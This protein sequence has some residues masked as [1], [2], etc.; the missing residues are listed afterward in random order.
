MR[1]KKDECKSFPAWLTSFSDLMSLLLTF[2]IL[3]YSMS[4]LDVS[5]AAKF[6]SYFQGE[7]AKYF[8][9]FSIVKPIK[10]YTKDLAKKLGKILARTLPISGY[11]IVV[12]KQYVLLRIFNRVLF[13]KNSFNLTPEAKKALDEVVKTIKMIDGNYTIRVE[14]HTDIGEPK[15]PID[16]IKDS[17]DLSLRRATAVIRYFISKGIPQDR[18]MA[19][20][21]GDTRPL[22]TWNNP[23][24]RARNSRVEIYIQ[25]AKERKD[26]EKLIKEEQQR[27][28][29]REKGIIVNG[30]NKT[31]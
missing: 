16:G 1:K 8:K 7:R 17:W 14:G 25:V 27:I 26:I 23:I 29:Y 31:E 5:K 30:T 2:F 24:L 10:F 11:Q 12:T 15:K 13:E 28:K 21:Y 4:S 20:G 9:K 3:L 19:V 22:Y 6:L 18:L